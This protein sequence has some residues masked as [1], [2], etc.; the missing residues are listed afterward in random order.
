MAYLVLLAILGWVV[1]GLRA[2]YHREDVFR[3]NNQKYGEVDPALYFMWFFGNIIGG[4]PRM[5][6]VLWRYVPRFRL[7]DERLGG[8]TYRLGRHSDIGQ[9]HARVYALMDRRGISRCFV[10][11][12]RHWRWVGTHIDTDHLAHVRSIREYKAPQAA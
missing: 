1:C 10:Q 9:L 7:I 2:M 12:R 4:L 6:F 8:R 5:L 11:E 3:D